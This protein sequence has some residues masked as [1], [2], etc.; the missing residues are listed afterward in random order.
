MRP[1]FL[2]LSCLL[3]GLSVA[4]PAHAYLVPLIGGLG[5]LLAVAFGGILAAATF[6][7]A[8]VVKWRGRNDTTPG[9]DAT[10]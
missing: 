2:L 10:D 5:W 8:L 9:D 4:A 1:T 7:W 6:V 3:I